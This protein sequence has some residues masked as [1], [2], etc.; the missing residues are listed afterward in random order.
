M[1]KFILLLIILFISFSFSGC[2]Y[3]IPKSIEIGNDDLTLELGDS[4]TLSA[5]VLPENANQKIKWSSSKPEIVSVDEEGKIITKEAG[6]AIIYAKSSNGKTDSIEITVTKTIKK[7]TDYEIVNIQNENL[8]RL[9]FALK[10]KNEISLDGDTV[11]ELRI[12][13]EDKQI[14][15]QHNYNLTS[16][17]FKKL[18]HPTKSDQLMAAIDIPYSLL[19]NGL[20]TIA[21]IYYRIVT[22]NNISL[23]HH[24]LLTGTQSVAYKQELM[25]MLDR[26]D[27]VTEACTNFT[28]DTSVNITVV[29]EGVPLNETVASTL[30]VDSLK[31]L[32]AVE[33]AM[34]DYIG[35][36]HYRIHNNTLILEM[37]SFENSEFIDK[38]NLGEYSLTIEDFFND[39][40]GENDDLYS[41]SDFAIYKKLDDNHYQMKIKMRDLVDDVSFFDELIGDEYFDCDVMIDFV[42]DLSSKELIMTMSF[43]YELDEMTSM[44]IIANYHVKDVGQ[45]DAKTLIELGY[46]EYAYETS[47][48]LISEN[49]VF[50]INNQQE[51]FFEKMPS[52]MKFYVAVDITKGFY[53]ISSNNSYALRY[54]IY[55]NNGVKVNPYEATQ[56]SYG[57]NFYMLE[58]NRY[59]LEL[60]N[61]TYG[62]GQYDMKFEIRK[63]D[64]VQQ[65]SLDNPLNYQDSGKMFTIT[66]YVES[67]FLSGTFAQDGVVELVFHLNDF[68][69]SMVLTVPGTGALSHINSYTKT[70]EFY[71]KKDVPFTIQLHHSD[72]DKY[73]IPVSF[74][75][76][77][78]FFEDKDPNGLYLT[79][80]FTKEMY[81]M[82]YGCENKRFNFKVQENGFYRFDFQMW[83][84]AW[85]TPGFGLYDSQDNRIYEVSYA[86]AYDLTVGEY[87]LIFQ[88]S[89]SVTGF[90]IKAV[91]V[92][93]VNKVME[94]K[95]DVY[96]R[97]YDSFYAGTS[98]NRYF[99]DLDKE[100]IVRVNYVTYESKP[101]TFE[102][103]K[104]NGNEKVL[105]EYYKRESNYNYYHLQPGRYYFEAKNTSGDKYYRF[106]FAFDRL[107][108]PS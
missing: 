31:N 101:F 103:Y 18:L 107:A 89:G 88:E 81:Y 104:D 11:V 4:K 53:A 96:S 40:N 76:T 44:E 97:Y 26:F 32:I 99:F 10:N 33:T 91:F 84:K 75:V 65:S 15:Y 37:P 92:Q 74:F 27:A 35:I 98:I 102:V 57:L 100:M 45:T 1:R 19:P 2:N 59:Y 77:V 51:F 64:Y 87:Y 85:H 56:S 72:T 49:Q 5:I 39:L 29:E 34:G 20:E 62:P 95:F 90:R 8:F 38:I 69:R 41:L 48:E 22:A 9:F 16:S 79:N 30:K 82:G 47:R 67:L 28:I 3:V 21:T 106:N 70:Y 80:E 7:V 66:N 58:S 78:N 105:Q 61:R 54:E 50:D 83:E 55:D 17:D 14:I 13:D 23:T 43:N 68:S 52:D 108:L 73:Y 6:T 24:F 25:E 63:M 36:Q 42:C 60:V 46:K 86:S 94:V 12:E 93:G 71:V